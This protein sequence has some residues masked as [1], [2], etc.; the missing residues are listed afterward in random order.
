MAARPDGPG[1]DLEHETGTR[2]STTGR[3][4]LSWP[5]PNWAA[6]DALDL[7]DA[8]LCADLDQVTVLPVD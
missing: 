6:E 5:P 7:L 1:L 4:G 8:L 2:R 3:V